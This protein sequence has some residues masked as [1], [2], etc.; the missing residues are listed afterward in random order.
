MEKGDAIKEE[1][2]LRQT[3]IEMDPTKRYRHE[4]FG[5][6]G[7][8]LIL[9]GT[10]DA[11]EGNALKPVY[12][13]LAKQGYS[14]EFFTDGPGAKILCS[15]NLK[16]Q[17]ISDRNN[18]NSAEPTLLKDISKIKPTL[19]VT[20]FSGSDVTGGGGGIDLALTAKG[21][22]ANIPVVWIGDYP[23][24][25]IFQ[26]YRGKIGIPDWIQP[27][28]LCTT[29]AAKENEMEFAPEFNPEHIIVTGQPAFDALLK[30]DK[31]KTKKDIRNK[32]GLKENEKLI[33]FM[34]GSIPE[35]NAKTLEVFTDGIKKIKLENYKL[36]MRRHPKDPAD[37]TFYDAI[38]KGLPIVDSKGWTT[39]QIGMTADCVATIDST[40]EYKAVIRNIPTVCILISDIL[41]TCPDIYPEGKEVSI[42]TVEDGTTPVIRTK[43]EAEH[44][45]SQ[46]FNPKFQQ[47]L[48]E[49][50]MRWSP[51][52]GNATERI[53]DLIVDL[54]HGVAIDPQNPR[55][56]T[57][58]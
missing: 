58:K 7:Q 33:V 3:A 4:G 39:D 21:I 12:E 14:L 18:E 31:E 37:T 57:Q 30:E 42:A 35:I 47:E 26:H 41:K 28:Y 52:D 17:E 8:L 54:A 19:I 15:D 2:T 32:L 50:R 49:K 55:Y 34:G 24:G 40:E 38:T 36:V 44:I 1:R 27:D 13:E 9:F 56:T 23:F 5:E 43:D 29:I 6:N 25:G 11:G 10:R 16:V 46:V 51:G 20:G 53:I 48:Q 45:L 22:D